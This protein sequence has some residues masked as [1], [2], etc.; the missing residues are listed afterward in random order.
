[1]TN[2]EKEEEEFL[3][4]ME[5]KYW[6]L[7]NLY[8]IT[9]K[10]EK[11][12][13]FKFNHEQQ[14]IWE[15][16]FKNGV[17]VADPEILKSR[18]LGITTFFVMV[19]LD[20][21][22]WN[23][24]INAFI[25]SH[26][27]DSIA[28][29]FRIVRYAHRMFKE[30]FP[31]LAPDLDRG[32]GSKYEYFFPG[33]NSRIAVGLK[34]R[35]AG[36]NRIHLSE[37]AFQTLERIGA[38]MASWGNKR[39][40]SETTANGMNWYRDDWQKKGVAYKERFFFS[41]LHRDEY[42]IQG[43]DTGAYT[44]EE[45]EYIKTVKKATSVKLSRSKME[46]RRMKI[47]Q[48]KSADMFDQE[49][50]YDDNI[51]FMTSGDNCFDASHLKEI[52]SRLPENEFYYE[53]EFKIMIPFDKSQT[54]SCGVDTSEGV[55]GDNSVATIYD[56]K[57]RQCSILVCG[58]T[59]PAAF[60]HKINKL[61][62]IYGGCKCQWPLLGVERNNHGH[63]VLLEL[64]P[65]HIDY[66]NLYFYT[67]DEERPG[68]LTDKVTRPIMIDVMIDG[69]DNGTVQLNDADT[70]DE[71]LTFVNI[72]GKMQASEG[73]KDDRVIATAIAIQMVIENCGGDIYN[74]INKSVLI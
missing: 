2:E 22:I 20:D 7:N 17:L 32:G 48:L 70:I 74:N 31:E 72:E 61:C 60:A 18:Q 47:E 28:K 1:M 16:C 63:A 10:D 6:R 13:I 30:E 4:N 11:D 26:D 44:K 33:H 41:W 71:C 8:H 59:K 25:Q 53:D 21:V 12:I 58:K 56:S 73:K 46:F 23:K 62:E 29:I 40:S 57:R 50:P 35:S 54:Y 38:T 27:S 3:T 15:R 24:N 65:D 14:Q 66:P 55:G 51:C 34:N 67:D 39:Y 68:W 19:Y 5:S 36:L 37:T 43:L 9:D 42:D 64:G 49:Y 45:K 52:L 69:V